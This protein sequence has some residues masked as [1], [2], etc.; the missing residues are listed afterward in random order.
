MSLSASVLQGMKS[1]QGVPLKQQSQQLTADVAIREAFI[2]QTESGNAFD[3]L[4]RQ[5]PLFLRA[6]VSVPSSPILAL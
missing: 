2:H 6:A 1:P 4:Q 3:L 5:H